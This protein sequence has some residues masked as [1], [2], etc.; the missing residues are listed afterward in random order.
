MS[1]L[2]DELMESAQ[3]A[4][5]ITRG[6]VEPSRVHKVRALARHV[7]NARVVPAV[8]TDDDGDE[9]NSAVSPEPCLHV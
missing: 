8:I 4:L 3:E 7:D 1:Q 2:F 9:T 6:E 5:A